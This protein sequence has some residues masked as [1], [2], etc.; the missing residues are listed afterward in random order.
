LVEYLFLQKK[1]LIGMKM[2]EQHL[3]QCFW[4]QH[5]LRVL[6]WWWW[7]ISY[8]YLCENTLKE[9]IHCHT[10]FRHNPL[11]SNN[12]TEVT[13]HVCC[14]NLFCGMAI[15][16]VGCCCPGFEHRMPMRFD[17]F[18]TRYCEVKQRISFQT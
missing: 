1:E 7:E 11:G 16:P 14:D 18:D 12:D 9:A 2:F 6:V 5:L 8:Q 13:Q 4:Q 10:S 3:F 15:L 17:Y